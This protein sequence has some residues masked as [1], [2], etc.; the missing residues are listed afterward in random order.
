MLPE[1]ASSVNDR[2]RLRSSVGLDPHQDSAAADLRGLVMK[3]FAIESESLVEEDRSLNEMLLLSGSAKYVVSYTGHLLMG[4]EEAYDKLDADLAAMDYL[5]IFREVGGRQII[6]IFSGRVQPAPRPWWPNALLLALTVISLLMV[7]TEVAI[8]EIAGLGAPEA[9]IEALI[10]NFFGE[11]WRGIP[12]AG[13]LLLILGAHE[14]GHFFAGRRHKLAVTLPY[15]IPAPFTFFGTFGA[16]IQLRQPMRSRKTLLD[17]GLAG[18][19]VGLLVAIPILYIGLR[20]SPVDVI[21]PGLLEGNSFLY[22]LMKTLTFGEFLP[23]GTYDVYI[24]QLARAGWVGLLVT[25]LNLIPIGQLDGGHVLYSLIGEHARRLY[26]PLMAAMIGLVL[27]TLSTS[28]IWVLWLVLLLLFGRIYA[29]PLDNIT[30]L[31]PRRRFLAALGLIVF[32]VTFVP[33]PL[34]PVEGVTLPPG[35]DSASILLPAAITLM[36]LF[37]NRRR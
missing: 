32:V 23:N 5:P 13:S 34:S 30:P 7:G 8:N 28:A 25:G 22:A 1:L 12:Y 11:L 2:P 4:S 36:A 17:I 37:M 29:V 26:A 35:T 33:L 6:H 19:L 20:T 27:V 24:N 16:F 9:E 15:F 18:P 21:Q 10:A 3:V 31:D 14:L